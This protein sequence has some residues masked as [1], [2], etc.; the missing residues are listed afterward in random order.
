MKW[1]DTWDERAFPPRLDV[2]KAVATQLAERCAEEEG[3][4][5]LAE[6]GP[7]WLRGFLDC[8][9]TYSTKFAV[10]RDRQRAL[11]S[12][13]TI[14]K[15]YFQKLDKV[16]KMYVFKLENMYNM[17]EKGFLL[18]YNNR[19]RVIVRH[20]W[21]MA[22]ETQDGSREWITVV[23]CTSAVQF[24]LP[25]MIIYKG[26]GIYHGCTSTVDNAETLF[27]HSNK[28]F[29]TDNLALEWL[30]HFDTWTS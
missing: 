18:G 5:L 16:L 19:A 8:H 4:P 13:P 1:V 12:N 6:L 25:P 10:T 14:I 7:T 21:R 28:G 27:A 22:T 26:K 9:P 20:R 24:M 29:I 11:V 30:H 17:D 23:E 15:D 2:F 3:N